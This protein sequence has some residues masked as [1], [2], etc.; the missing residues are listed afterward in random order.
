[1]DYDLPHV[2]PSP[3]QCT[4]GLLAVLGFDGPQVQ[5]AAVAEDDVG[6]EMGGIGG[7][8]CHDW[9]VFLPLRSHLELRTSR[10][11][12]GAKFERRIKKTATMRLRPTLLHSSFDLSS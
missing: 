10:E 8:C 3:G 1:M 5:R 11:V 4:S 9:R 2:P 7:R 6:F 12:R